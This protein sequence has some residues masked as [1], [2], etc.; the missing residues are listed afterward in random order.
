MIVDGVDLTPQAGARVPCSTEQYLTGATIRSA[1]RQDGWLKLVT[2]RG[3]IH[4]AGGRVRLGVYCKKCGEERLVEIVTTA[5]KE[6]AFCA[7]CSN[8]WALKKADGRA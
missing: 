2:D 1:E 3:E 6:Q 4:L 5:G 7:V 8:S